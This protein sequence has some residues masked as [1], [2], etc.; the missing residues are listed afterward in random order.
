MTMP[1][2]LALHVNDLDAARAFY[3]GVLG[4]L[5]G[6]SAE[7]WVDF[8]FYGHQLSLHI[9]P[10]TPTHNTG[11]VGHDAV[12]M[13]HFGLVLG[14]E[15][16]QAVVARLEEAG[17]KFALKPHVRFEGEP[18]E[19]WTFFAYD[20]AGNAIEI[21]GFAHEAAIFNGAV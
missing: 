21:K 6:R 13:P 20:P 17:V 7:T 8:D 19:Q 10:V 3:G 18:G 12:P 16:W 4:C 11:H 15:D 5:E 1:F 2:H 14:L 9:G